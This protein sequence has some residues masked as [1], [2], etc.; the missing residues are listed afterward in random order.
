LTELTAGERRVVLA[1]LEAAAAG[2]LFPMAETRQH[3]GVERDELLR[4]VQQFPAID[5]SRYESTA[6]L[7]I[8]R[9]MLEAMKTARKGRLPSW[10]WKRRRLAGLSRDRIDEVRLKWMGGK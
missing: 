6:F 1:C 9:S 4:L 10:P 5:D 2:E 8:D 7:A 3:I